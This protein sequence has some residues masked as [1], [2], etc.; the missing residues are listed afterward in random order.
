MRYHV[1]AIV[2]YWSLPSTALAF[3]AKD[4]IDMGVCEDA[5]SIGPAEC[6]DQQVRL[7]MDAADALE[8]TYVTS[9]FCPNEASNQADLLLNK[10]YQSAMAKTKAHELSMAESAYTGQEALLRQSQRAWLDVRDTTCELMVTY[11]AI[12]SG[13]GALSSW[14][15]ARLTMQRIA[16]LRTEIGTYLD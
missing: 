16:D 13:A 1:A 15:Q 12:M 4:F 7:C 5:S 11:G 8:D 3:E 2:L 9:R 14:C 10:F 6:V